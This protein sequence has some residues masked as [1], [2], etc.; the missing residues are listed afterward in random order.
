[1]KVRN[2]LLFAVAVLLLTSCA[3]SIDT[4][5]CVQIAHTGESP[6]GFWWGLWNGITIAFSFIG[7][8]FDDS[9]AVYN[10]NNTGKLYDLGFCLPAV[11]TLLSSLFGNND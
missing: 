8:L 6:A 1:M 7:S 11:L 2:L 10:V 3:T 4:E 5:R 9:I